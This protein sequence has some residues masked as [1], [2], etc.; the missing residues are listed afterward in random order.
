MQ[1]T[2]TPPTA[3][4]FAQGV[5]ALNVGD[6]QRARALLV[7]VVQAQPDNP[8]AWLWLSGAVDAYS[9]RRYCLERVLALDPQHAAAQRGLARLP[10]GTLSVS[11][12]PEPPLLVP[13]EPAPV[14]PPAGTRVHSALMFTAVVPAEPTSSAFNSDVPPPAEP[15][16]QHAH[17]TTATAEE[18]A[19]S[20]IDVVVRLF[21]SHLSAEQIARKLCEE[22]AMPWPQAEALVAHVEAHHRKR[23]ARRQSPI[24]IG[25]GICTLLGGLGLIALY[26]ASMLLTVDHHSLPRPRAFQY[27]GLGVMMT[28]GSLIGLGQTIWSMFK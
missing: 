25:L 27:L 13:A 20:D 22:Y 4:V 3:D 6:T 15:A 28:L 18:F 9:E 11:P 16:A 21:G 2:L 24:L 8:S 23:I 26:G 5:K 7:Q 10:A 14:Q 12:L 19:Q 1:S 17:A